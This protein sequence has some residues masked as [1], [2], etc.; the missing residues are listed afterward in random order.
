MSGQSIIDPFSYATAIRDGQAFSATLDVDDV[1]AENGGPGQQEVL[2]RV[3]AG[4]AIRFAF[5]ISGGAD[6][7]A[8]FYADPTT[9]ADGAAIAVLNRNRIS[10]NTSTTLAFDGPTV[11]DD[12]TKLRRFFSNNGQRVNGVDGLDIEKRGWILDPGDYLLQFD[13]HSAGVTDATI[14]MIWIDL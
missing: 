14:E 13:N 9:G 5:A 6:C 8:G 11:S 4:A 3:A 10:T 1:P 2:L 12:G 7:W